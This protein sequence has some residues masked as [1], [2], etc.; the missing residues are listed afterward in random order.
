MARCGGKPSPVPPPPTP[1]G[2]GDLQSESETEEQLRAPCQGSR[3][4]WDHEGR[5]TQL[6]GS[7]PGGKRKTCPQLASV[8]LQ[9]LQDDRP[10]AT[11][12]E[13]CGSCAVR[14]TSL[15]GTLRCT[16]EGRHR[17]GKH[18]PHHGLLC[19]HHAGTQ[20]GE[21]VGSQEVEELK[22][23]EQGRGARRRSRSR[24]SSHR[25]NSTPAP[26]REPLPTAA[27]PRCSTAYS[28]VALFCLT[29]GVKRIMEGA[30]I[31]TDLPLQSRAPSARTSESEAAT[32]PKEF[33]EVKS[34]LQELTQQVRSQGRPPPG[35]G[36]DDPLNARPPT[37]P[38]PRHR[39]SSAGPAVRFNPQSP[40]EGHARFAAR[41]ESPATFFEH[42]EPADNTLDIPLE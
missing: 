19:E 26:E 8:S 18:G 34:M 15:R 21:Q 36:D 12:V 2:V 20:T 25:S 32:S 27:C 7:P 33:A 41:S 31:A 14:Y 9:T 39:S 24:G 23:E 3:I 40:K 16:H 4:C 29:C 22:S 37:P 30:H 11:M 5:A 10:G 17:I 13:L 38:K 6:F 35:Q 28:A 1:V 42:E